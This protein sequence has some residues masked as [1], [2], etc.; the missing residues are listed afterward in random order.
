MISV[1]NL[2]EAER[3]YLINSVRGW[4]QLK[5]DAADGWVVVQEGLAGLVA[6]WRASYST[7]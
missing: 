6:D 5:R 7:T 2:R 1:D 3:V 4:M